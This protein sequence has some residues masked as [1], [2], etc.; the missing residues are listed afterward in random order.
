MGDA[1]MRFCIVWHICN[2]LA[3]KEQNIDQP[4]ASLSLPM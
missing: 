1:M 4:R 2:I 3:V